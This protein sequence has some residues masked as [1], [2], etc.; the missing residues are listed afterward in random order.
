MYKVYLRDSEGVVDNFWIMAE[1]LLDFMAMC[2]T[3]VS[4]A[5][6]SKKNKAA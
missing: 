2:D 6:V 1:A 3:L 5:Q 4:V